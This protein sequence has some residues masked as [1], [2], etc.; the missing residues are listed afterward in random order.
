MPKICV[1]GGAKKAPAGLSNAEVDRLGNRV[2]RPPGGVAPE[3]RVLD[4]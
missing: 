2:G 4:V 1:G 3:E